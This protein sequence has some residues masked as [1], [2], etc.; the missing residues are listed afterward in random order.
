M[1]Y[2]SKE[3]RASDFQKIW[4][5]LRSLNYPI[6][7]EGKRDKIALRKLGIEGDIIQLN[8][9]KSVL[10]TIERISQRFGRSSQ[11]VILMDWDKTGNKLAKQ[12]VSFGEACDLVPNDKIRSALSKFS[13]KEISCVEELPTFVFSLGYKDLFL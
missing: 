5:D 9:G 1:V 11:F 13:A 2:L 6:I 4:S 10:S 12:L 7:V 8:D 3:K